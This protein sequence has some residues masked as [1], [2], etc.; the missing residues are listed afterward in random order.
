VT[1]H[2]SVTQCVPLV[3]A[4]KRAKAARPALKLPE[5]VA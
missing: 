4:A 1:I 2:D 3:L 5:G